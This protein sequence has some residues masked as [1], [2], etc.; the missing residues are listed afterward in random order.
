MIAK[1]G[2]VP[3]TLLSILFIICI[4]TLWDPVAGRVSWLLEVGPGLIGI[5]VLIAT[6]R[7]FRFSNW[8]YYAVFFH[9]LILVYG[10]FYTYSKTPLGNWAMDVFDLSRNHY[11]RI[12]HIALGFFP[13]FIFR[14]VYLRLKIMK[15]GGW[16]IFTALAS[17][18]GIAAFWEILEWWV[19]LVAAPDVGIA[20][21]G[22]Q[23][24]IWDAH[25]DMFLA[26]VGAGVAFLFV[27]WHDRSILR[28][29]KK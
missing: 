27:K 25:W 24:D 21:L 13:L 5:V 3:V 17:I 12:G 11:D 23:G 16:F 4:A 7:K 22:S 8:V 18:L 19:A 14:E 6:Y 15:P 29:K 9:T 28:V 1:E 20:F 10:G 2:R 26:L